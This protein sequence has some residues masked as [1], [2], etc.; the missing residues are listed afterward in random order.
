[1]LLTAWYIFYLFACCLFPSYQS[2]SFPVCPSLCPT[3]PLQIPSVVLYAIIFVLAFICFWNYI[4]LLMRIGNL[5]VLFVVVDYFSKKRVLSVWF[6]TLSPVL[7][8]GPS[9]KWVFSKCLLNEWIC[10]YACIS[11]PCSSWVVAVSSRGW[12]LPKTQLPVLC[13]FCSL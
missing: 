13:N 9:T 2:V 4:C 12:L 8:P 3:V 7:R 5:S 1:M 10:A 6:T 11:H